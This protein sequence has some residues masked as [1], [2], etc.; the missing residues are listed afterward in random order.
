MD[1]A[2]CVDGRE[3]CMVY[4]ELKFYFNSVSIDIAD[5]IISENAIRSVDGDGE[6]KRI[7]SGS[8]LGDAGRSRCQGYQAAWL[9]DRNCWEGVCV[10]G[11][12]IRVLELYG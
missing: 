10:D 5:P 3:L 4:H 6:N 1:V 11:V 9:N 7:E 8:N 12:T 2:V